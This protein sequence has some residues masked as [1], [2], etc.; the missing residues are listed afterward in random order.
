MSIKV[1][2]NNGRSFDRYTIIDL[3][4]PE[5]NDCYTALAASEDPFHPQGFGQWCSAMLGSHLGREI[6]FDQ[7]PAKVQTFV[8]AQLEL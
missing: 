6:S 4:S 5:G 7:L 2:D 1:Y 3:S 8:K